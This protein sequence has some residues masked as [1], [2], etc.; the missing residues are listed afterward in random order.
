MAKKDDPMERSQSFKEKLAELRNTRFSKVPRVR[1]VMQSFFAS[2]H[3]SDKNRSDSRARV[4]DWALEHWPGLVPAQAYEGKAFEHDQAGLRIAATGNADGSVW[5]FRSEH[6]GEHSRNWVTE[7]VIADLGAVDALGVRNSCST[8]ETGPVPASMPRFLRDFVAHHQLLDAGYPVQAT[9]HVVEEDDAFGAFID[10]LTSAERNLPIV[11]LTQSL[12]GGRYAISPEKLA[13]KVQGLAHVICLPPRTT[14]NLTDQMGK[15]ASVFGGAIRTYYPGFTDDVD[16]R[17]HPL[18]L[19]QRIAEWEFEGVRGPEAF[20]EYLTGQMHFYSVSTR[21]K[22]DQLP[23]YFSIRR[24]FLDK[25]GKSA[26]E[27]LELLRL[28]LEEARSNAE[29]WK[30]LAN[31]CDVQA[32]GAEEEI[33]RLVAQNR[34]L[35]D[36]LRAQRSAR[37]EAEPPIPSSYDEIPAWL[38]TYFADR[39]VLHGRAARSLKG[40]RFKDVGL[41]ARA[42]KL[43]GEEY[44]A[45]CAN[46]DPSQRK[47]LVE[48][49]DAGLKA[50]SIEYNSHAMEEG[51]LGEFREQ[52]TIDYRIGQKT[53]QVLGPHL[54][55]GNAK[56][57][58]YTMRIYFLWDDERQMVVVGHLPAHLDTR[59][60]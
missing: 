7:A 38:D 57:D 1:H 6:M 13:R 28:E 54:K 21:E 15:A 51:R 41:V 3:H 58:H 50:L 52:Y 10:L 25:P 27:S 22:L 46:P 36:A 14:F 5:A 49:W 20:L 37:G 55:Y 60:S 31:D 24:A 2:K 35:S 23:S 8:L 44:W 56:N 17:T 47:D 19:P 16:V 33:R 34:V 11:V 43:L 48:R 59:K 39:I 45:M 53:R 4:L 40:A 42:L 26:E 9:P 18:I 32:S 29:V 12:D 30:A